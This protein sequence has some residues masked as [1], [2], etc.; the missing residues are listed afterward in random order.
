HHRL[1]R[2][3]VAGSGC[4]LYDLTPRHATPTRKKNIDLPDTS[5]HVLHQVSTVGSWK[6]AS[7]KPE[8]LR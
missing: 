2:L 1:Q 8:T 6:A 3:P 7:V 4:V 5:R